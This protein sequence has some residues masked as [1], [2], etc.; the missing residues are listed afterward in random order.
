LQLYRQ[1]LALRA[2]H[3]VPNLPGIHALGAR[4]LGPQA[5]TVRWQLERGGELRID[6]N[7][8]PTAQVADLPAHAE[9]LF[10]CSESCVGSTQL[11]PY[12]TLVSLLPTTPA[13][14]AHD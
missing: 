6:L 12:T 3:I 7:L 9:R 1:L 13:E 2:R 8:G 11:P 10:S 14:P 5:L 4:V